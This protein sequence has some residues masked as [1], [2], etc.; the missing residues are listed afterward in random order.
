MSNVQA[1]KVFHILLS[2]DEGAP[3]PAMVVA[4]S[5]QSPPPPIPLLTAFTQFR[6]DS[7]DYIISE[8][9]IGDLANFV[10]EH[11]EWTLSRLYRYLVLYYDDSIN[12]LQVDAALTA[13]PFIVGALFI[14][15]QFIPQLSTPSTVL[16][17]NTINR[18][19][20]GTPN[21]Y[22]NDLG[23]PSAW[24]LSEGSGYFGVTD[25]G[26]EVNHPAFKTFDD[27]GNYLGGNVLNGQYNQYDVAEGD[28]NVDEKQ[29]VTIVPI[30]QNCEDPENPGFA[31]PSFVGHG[32]HVA[33]IMAAN[34]NVSPENGIC[35][36]CSISVMKY[37]R[38]RSCRP[39]GDEFLFTSLSS[40]S[41]LPE[42]ITDG[43]KILTSL[44]SGVINFS[45]GIENT[46]ANYCDTIDQSNRNYV[47]CEALT[48]LNH[49]NTLLVTSAGNNRQNIQFPANDS[50]AVAAGGTDAN[51]LFW[52]ESPGTGGPTSNN[53]PSTCPYA[54]S[55]IECGSTS[56]FLL[57]GSRTD[58]VTQ[59]KDVHSLF[60]TGEEWNSFIG[61]TDASDG[62]ANDGYGLCTGTS[63]SSPQTAAIMQLMRSTQPLLPNGDWNPST[64][65][66]I[67]N[68]LNA[69]ATL[70]QSGAGHD[71]H[72]GYGLP[73]ARL[74]LEKLLGTSNG[75]LMKNRLTPMFV[76]HSSA[77]NNHVYTSFPQVATAFLLQNGSF[78]LP[79]TNV[80]LVNEFTDFWYDHNLQNVPVQFPPPRA[81]FYVFTTN[82]NPFS[83]TKNLIPLRKMEKTVS[84][85][86]NDTYAVSN[87]EIEFYHSEGYSFG[88][89]EGYIL[90]FT[91]CFPVACVGATRLYRDETDNLNHKLVASNTAPP[92][93]VMLGF[94][95]LNQDSDGDGLIDGQEIILGTNILVADSDGD[96]LTDGQEYPPAGVPLSDPLI[97]DITDV[98]FVNGFE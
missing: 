76:M 3:T 33:G 8:R 50:R 77:Q 34:N 53:D 83:G 10:S 54:P 80:A 13:D 82:N 44:G 59:A 64:L 45:G 56:S 88:G 37:V 89:I 27:N 21:S 81:Q 84:G 14:N 63:M 1:E 97:S 60:Y 41:R 51:G 94:V 58:V 73:N 42:Y 39:F 18:L 46:V 20:R 79:D 93:S 7:V 4:E 62:V 48:L 31:N 32:T 78:Y 61:C 28:F 25:T 30:K 96:N 52:N 5:F 16:P 2:A 92:N 11:P 38:H 26:I 75:I 40:D 74:A 24:E 17:N 70:S 35:K 55:N 91:Q 22:L 9:P 95:Y 12:E 87:A 72:Y 71:N 90:P 68:V 29:P 85:N 86:R 47:F 65:I 15:N 69:T 98:I 19:S 49:R 43:F 66:G 36:N 23:I 57:A 6:P 67:T